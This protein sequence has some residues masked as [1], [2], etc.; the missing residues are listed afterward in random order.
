M[1]DVP[2]RKLIAPPL[3]ASAELISRWPISATGVATAGFAV[4][5]MAC[6]CIAVHRPIAGAGFIILSGL[7]GSIARP[8]SLLRGQGA[9]IAYLEAVFVV[10]VRAGIPFAFAFADPSRALASAFLLVG[11]A[12]AGTAALAL[13]F[14]LAKQA[15]ELGGRDAATISRT[16]DL[17]E[18]TG[19]Y[20]A[21]CIACLVPAWFGIIAYVLGVLCFVAVGVRV[22]AAIE[23][24][25]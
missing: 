8:L 11:F 20:V 21:L 1:F 16:G 19:V 3:A 22:A 2:L 24:R 4:G 14:F 23:R 18:T 15:Y 6:G 25:I 7:F 9:L 5:L 13:E 12:G 17:S 10:L